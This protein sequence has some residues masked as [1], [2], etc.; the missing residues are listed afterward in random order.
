MKLLLVSTVAAAIMIEPNDTKL[1]LNTTAQ[2]DKTICKEKSFQNF[3]PRVTI[4]QAGLYDTVGP[5]T[6]QHF[7]G[8]YFILFLFPCRI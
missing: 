5:F 8:V 2:P 1:F 6:L 7:D 3:S 4:S